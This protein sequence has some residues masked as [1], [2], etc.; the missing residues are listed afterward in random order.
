MDNRKIILS[1]YAAASLIIW[2]LTRSAINALRLEWYAFRRIPGID[3]IQEGVPFALAAAT[4]VILF[5]H[6]RATTFLDEVVVE[7]KKVSWS[8]RED[9]TRSTT[10]VVI[11][12]IVASL[13]LASFD[14][15][16]GKVIGALLK[17][18]WT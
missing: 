9:V 14:L 1:A 5:F 15:V 4:F 13:I 12:I 11:C 2:F 7:L 18:N 3:W 17:G 10:V 8:S 6:P 16:W